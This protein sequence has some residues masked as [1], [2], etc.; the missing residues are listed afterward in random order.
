LLFRLVLPPTAYF[1]CPSSPQMAQPLE[2]AWKCAATPSQHVYALK[3]LKYD[4]IGHERK[5]S[6]IIQQ[7]IVEHLVNLLAGIHKS[8]GKH[9]IS[10]DIPIPCTSSAS[11]AE[12][13]LIDEDQV[14]L[15]SIFVI[16]S[17]AQGKHPLQTALDLSADLPSF[18]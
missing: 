14:R 17:L 5:K 7:G 6:M 16:A 10:Q 11:A 3:H 13:D 9:R 12:P 4:I 18:V 15:Q 2:L 1:S 8:T